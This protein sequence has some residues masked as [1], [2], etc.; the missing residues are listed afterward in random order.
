MPHRMVIY[1][2]YAPAPSL[3][4]DAPGHR[5]F[6]APGMHVWEQDVLEFL[7]RYLGPSPRPLPGGERE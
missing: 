3:G 1:E 4:A 5:V 6:S 7:G 2:P